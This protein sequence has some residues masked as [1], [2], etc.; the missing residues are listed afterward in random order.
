MSIATIFLNYTEVDVSFHIHGNEI[1]LDKIHNN[2]SGE[3][4]DAEKLSA[5][6]YKEAV[7]KIKLVTANNVTN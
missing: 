7:A 2:T 3:L 6:L 4:V 5:A 1:R